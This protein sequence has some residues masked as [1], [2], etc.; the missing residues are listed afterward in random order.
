MK[1]ILLMAFV[2]VI[3]L[4]VS[5]FAEDTDPWEILKKA[6]D[7]YKSMETYKSEGVRTTI[8]ERDNEKTEMVNS[9]SILLKK[10][11]LYRVSYEETLNFMPNNNVGTIWSDGTRAYYYKDDTK[12]YSEFS[13]NEAVTLAGAMSSPMIV[14]EF[15]SSQPVAFFE[16]LIDVKLEGVEIIGD[17]ECYV[18]S[19]DSKFGGKEIFWITKKRSL[20]IKHTHFLEDPKLMQKIHDEQVDQFLKVMEQRGASE[21]ELKQMKTEMQ[22][23]MS[24]VKSFREDT[25]TQVSSPELTVADFQFVLPEGALLE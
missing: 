11:N 9:Y 21:E 12:S 13:P 25:Q 10:P 7:T 19:A 2:M 4:S 15:L 16:N 5:C 24:N 3:I 20:I 6:R 23:A 22:M 1:R 14:F 17:E 18:I 8:T